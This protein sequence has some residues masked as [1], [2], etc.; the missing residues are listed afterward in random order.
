M[1]NEIIYTA[2]SIYDL[3]N[4]LGTEKDKIYSGLGDI[5]YLLSTITSDAGM[6]KS[7]YSEKLG[8]TI[9]KIQAE[10]TEFNERMVSI[11]TDIN[12][13]QDELS[14]VSNDANQ[15][16]DN[17]NLDLESFSNSLNNI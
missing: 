5:I 13:A 11:I 1:N 3:T 6:F 8:E 2:D 15:Q 7:S 4:K 9:N 16:L 12:T 14:I 10:Q 17:V